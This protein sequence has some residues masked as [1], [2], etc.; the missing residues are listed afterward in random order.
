M[1]FNQLI[2]KQADSISHQFTESDFDLSYWRSKK[3]TVELAGGRGASQKIVIDGQFYVLRHYLRGGLIARL[4]HDQYIWSGLNRTRPFV[5]QQAIQHALKNNLPVAEV[6]AFNVIKQGLFYRASI[7][8]RFINNEGT[9]AS[10]LYDNELAENKWFELGQLIKSLHRANIYHAD[11]NANNILI[12][13]AGKF[14]IIDF[15]KAEINIPL[16]DSAQKNVHR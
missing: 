15:D 16:G 11:L 8:S 5:E 14:H 7:I 9:L 1:S 2:I 13:E 3:A 4:L 10:F 12:D 6:V